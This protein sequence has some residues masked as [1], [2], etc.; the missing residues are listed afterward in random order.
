VLAILA[1]L[2]C[3]GITFWNATPKLDAAFWL[4]TVALNLLMTLAIG[5]RMWRMRRQCFAAV[6]G[7]E[8]RMSEL[9]AM[10]FES[11]ALY[12]IAGIGYATLMLQSRPAMEAT[13]VMGTLFQILAF[14]NPSV[15]ILRVAM[16]I[17]FDNYI[18]VHQRNFIISGMSDKESVSPRNNLPNTPE[19]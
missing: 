14:L 1:Q 9:M 8:S 16:G 5:T 13:L 19:Q 4:A 10:L 18:T 15:I 2:Y 6:S 11:A 7:S 3:V 12:T 17:S